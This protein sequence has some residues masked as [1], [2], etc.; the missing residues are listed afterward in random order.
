MILRFENDR[1]KFLDDSAAQK[2]AS[3]LDAQV[4]RNS[5]CTIFSEI[6]KAVDFRSASNYNFVAQTK[7]RAQVPSIA[8][9][10]QSPLLRRLRL[11]SITNAPHLQAQWN[12]RR[13]N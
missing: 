1:E 7:Y 8:L 3:R 9:S 13:R 11:N 5:A 2:K 12:F 10:L 4:N 6:Q